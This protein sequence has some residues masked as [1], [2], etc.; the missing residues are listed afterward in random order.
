[1]WRRQIKLAHFTQKVVGLISN[2]PHTCW[3]KKNISLYH[4]AMVWWVFFMLA[5]I[6]I[7][8]FGYLFWF[9]K[10]VTSFAN[11][12]PLVCGRTDSLTWI[13]E[14]LSCKH[15]VAPSIMF[16]TLMLHTADWSQMEVNE[17]RSEPKIWLNTHKKACKASHDQLLTYLPWWECQDSFSDAFWSLADFLSIMARKHN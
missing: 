5:T 4:N 3:L 15:F 11:I 7:I 9:V 8:Q 14:Q 12:R 13:F 1:M 10:H 2:I 17:L 16:L 6:T